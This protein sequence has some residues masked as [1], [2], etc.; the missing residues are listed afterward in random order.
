MDIRASTPAPFDNWDC[1]TV[2][3]L[4]D[5]R[6]FFNCS[7]VK[8]RQSSVRLRHTLS[9]LRRACRSGE[10][11]PPFTTETLPD[12]AALTPNAVER[13]KASVIVASREVYT[14]PLKTAF[15]LANADCRIGCAGFCSISAAE[16]LALRRCFGEEDKVVMAVFAVRGL[17][18]VGVYIAAEDDEGSLP[19]SSSFLMRSLRSSSSSQTVDGA[20]MDNVDSLPS[21]RDRSVSARGRPITSEFEVCRLLRI[22]ESPEW[23][24]LRGSFREDRR[25]CS[26]AAVG[27]RGEVS[28]LVR[29]KR[30]RGTPT[31]DRALDPRIL[32]RKR[33]GSSRGWADDAGVWMAL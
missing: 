20:V 10:V 11:Y 25:S 5:G 26:S 12:G 18:F 21:A 28:G 17:S 29:L 2:P 16:M 22:V 23:R 6:A 1:T 31:A 3:R 27:V 32:Y 24:L 7:S 19:V 15:A 8:A 33:A 14:S 30:L 9:A 13:V 4:D